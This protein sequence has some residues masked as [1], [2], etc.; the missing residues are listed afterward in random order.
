MHSLSRILPLTVDSQ[1]KMTAF[2][3]GWASDLFENV[4]SRNVDLFMS[5]NLS[6]DGWFPVGRY[7]M[8]AGTNAHEFTVSSNDVAL[9]YRPLYVDSF[10][11]RSS[12]SAS[13]S[14]PTATVLRIRMRCS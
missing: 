10:E 13:I 5:T 2:E 7:L 9:A 4:D 8:P 1:G 3:V 14:I 12:A 6:V 11:Q